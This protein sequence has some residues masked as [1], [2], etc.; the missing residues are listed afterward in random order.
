MLYAICYWYD[1]FC[2][3]SQFIAFMHG[4][5][6]LEK[7]KKPADMVIA[8]TQNET[9]SQREEREETTPEPNMDQECYL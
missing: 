7:K 1:R 6:L 8:V 5:T 4:S 3:V 9:K 2:Y